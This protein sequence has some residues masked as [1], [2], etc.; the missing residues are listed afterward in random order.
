M[1]VCG[2]TD[3]DGAE[4]RFNRCLTSGYTYWVGCGSISCKS[5]KQPNVSLSSTKAEYKAL[6]DSCKEEIWLGNIL[7]EL[8]CCTHEPIPLHVNNKGAEAL[9]HNPEHHTR[10]KHIDARYHFIRECVSLGK[11]KVKHVST[12]DMIANMLTK[13]LSHI[14][15][16]Q[17]CKMFGI[18]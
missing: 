1:E 15:L 17:H 7:A 11:V 9:A 3:S 13:T 16:A 10:T 6:Y 4:D 18:V 8:H 12:I 14:L 2:Y 5:R